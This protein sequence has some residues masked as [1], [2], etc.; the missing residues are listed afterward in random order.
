MLTTPAACNDKEKIQYI[1]C[2][3]QS[4]L[5]DNENVLSFCVT[6]ALLLVLLAR[7]LCMHIFQTVE[8]F[9][10]FLKSF[11]LKKFPVPYDFNVQHIKAKYYNV[12]HEFFLVFRFETGLF[13]CR[14]NY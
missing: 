10:M 3:C 6:C 5:N 13:L 12:K 1:I 2:Y 11:L 14:Q 9:V 4:Q 7:V 8:R